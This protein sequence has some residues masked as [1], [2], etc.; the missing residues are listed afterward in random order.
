MWTNGS[1]QMTMNMAPT[2]GLF[3]SQQRPGDNVEASD[4][5]AENTPSRDTQIGPPTNQFHPPPEYSYL[6]SLTPFLGAPQFYNPTPFNMPPSSQPSSGAIQGY[7]SYGPSW[8]AYDFP[9]RGHGGPQMFPPLQLTGHWPSSSSGPRVPPAPPQNNPGIWPISS[10]STA[11]GQLPS[12]PGRPPIGL[13]TKSFQL[14]AEPC[15]PGGW[16]HVT[17]VSLLKV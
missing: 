17:V 13:T 16:P 4:N 5:N 3:G 2:G 15:R 9:Q 14:A 11:P 6:P 1:L 7:L 8:Q 12:A 10:A